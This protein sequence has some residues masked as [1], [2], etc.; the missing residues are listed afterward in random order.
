[1][2]SP[3]EILAQDVGIMRADEL[4]SQLRAAGYIIVRK[5]AIGQAQREAV[6][7]WREDALVADNKAR[8]NLGENA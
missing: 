8:P 1:M 6:A 2:T 4:I 7:Q 5:G 3:S